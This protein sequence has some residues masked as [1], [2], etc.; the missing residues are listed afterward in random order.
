MMGLRIILVIITALF[1]S[2]GSI[3]QKDCIP[4][5][6]SS[7]TSD[8]EAYVYDLVNAL[9]PSQKK[10]L[11]SRL[12][13]FRKKTSNEVVLVTS[14]DL[15]GYEPIKYAYKIGDKWGIGRAD[16]DNGVVIVYKPKTSDS[17]GRVAIA[18]G[19]GLEGALTDLDCGFII[20]EELIPLFK[21]GKIYQGFSKGL[22]VMEDIIQEEYS[23]SNYKSEKKSIP[24]QAFIPV[25]VI[26][27]FV[28][29]WLFQVRNYAKTNN[30][31]FWKAMV[32]LSKTSGTHTGKWRR[33]NGGY[34]GFGGYRGGGGSSSGGGF[35]GFGGGS[36]G[37]GGASGSW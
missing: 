16:L 23:F 13:K 3:A 22:D 11:S 27:V 1:F 12:A 28:V 2:L 15:C 6:P 33:F 8:S 14:S 26:L 20:D 18:P 31:S 4:D 7:R 32:I 5:V 19:D 25:L 34:G 10:Q 35:G 30:I 37:G 36:F 24:W 9:S 29:F 17:D 21:K